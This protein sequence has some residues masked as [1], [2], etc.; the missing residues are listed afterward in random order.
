M[1]SN[2]LKESFEE[3]ANNIAI[4]DTFSKISYKELR[5]KSVIISKCIE[6]YYEIRKIKCKSR[7]SGILMNK[8]IDGIATILSCLFSDVIFVPID[9]NQPISVINYMVEN[10]FIN[11]LLVDEKHISIADEV[12]EKYIGLEYINVSSVK[13]DDVIDY[14][15]NCKEEN[16]VMYN[17]YTSGSTGMPKAVVQRKKSVL[18]FAK[19]YQRI[20]GLKSRDRMTL[21]S[22][23]GH[24]AA[25]LDIFSCFLSGASLYANDLRNIKAVL[26][27]PR[28]LLANEITVWHSVPSVY[29]MVLKKKPL[30]Q[31]SHHLRIVVLGGERVRNNDFQIFEGISNH[32]NMSFFNLYGQTES[33][34][35]AG[36]FIKS[37]EECELLGYPIKDMSLFVKTENDRIVKMKSDGICEES[38]ELD[39][40]RNCFEKGEIVLMSD[41][42][43]LGYLNLESTKNF[44][45]LKSGKRVYIT[46][47][48]V[49]L[50]SKNEF[51]MIGRKDFQCK[52]NGHR[53]ELGAIE[54]TI[55]KIPEINECVVGI[56][57]KENQLT[58]CAAVNLSC[59]KTLI[60]I[61]QFIGKY[62][63]NHMY[64]NSIQY[65]D[66]FPTTIT[67]KIDRKAILENF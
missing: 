23:F 30:A 45:N 11:L 6:N 15:F 21:F 40:I 42:I 13:A 51:R 22:S 50:N 9:E 24:D 37:Q 29:R 41:S 26:Q 5:K 59:K 65:Y 62:L 46:G 53:V 55:L 28:W 44:L 58:V 3:F 19:E 16:E 18:H 34:F 25:I 39:E 32:D 67:G 4:V 33:S 35:S 54:N 52:L 8:D 47:D 20:I 48:Y 36:N 17:L 43:S 66:S 7:V 10:S 64:I 57:D 49:N 27:L 60:E 56:K 2:S 31:K 38:N 61:N 12:K 63:P 14:Q 1:L